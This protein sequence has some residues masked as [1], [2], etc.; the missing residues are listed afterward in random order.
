MIAR[1]A[2]RLRL[3]PA[4]PEATKIELI[5]KNIDHPHR[6][7]FTDPIFQSIRE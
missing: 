5:D 7:V 6:I 2:R 3:D 1:P 4:K